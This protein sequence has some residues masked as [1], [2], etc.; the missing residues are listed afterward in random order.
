[1]M[2]LRNVCRNS[3]YVKYVPT[4]PGIEHFRNLD[5]CEL[6]FH[7]WKISDSDFAQCQTTYH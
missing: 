6:N 2:K 7:N 1:M 5:L 4:Q 3:V